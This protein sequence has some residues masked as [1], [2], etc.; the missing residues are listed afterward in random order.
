M[1]A[2][3]AQ[4]IAKVLP[5][6]FEPAGA[7]GVAAFFLYLLG[8]SEIYPGASSRFRRIDAT[9]DQ[10]RSVLVQVE[11]H[12]LFKLHFQFVAMQQPIPPVHC[13][14]PSESFRMSA[15]AS[16]KRSQLAASDSSCARPV[17]VKR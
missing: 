8:T 11:T 10:F 3:R 4:R 15:T 12:F 7:A 13:A 5:K 9:S 16:V 17:P 6:I 2:E 1:L 14:P